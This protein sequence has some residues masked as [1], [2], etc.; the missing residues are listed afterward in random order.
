MT[1][2]RPLQEPPLERSPGQ[3]GQLVL[4]TGMS[5]AGMSVALKALEDLGYEAVDNLRLSLV[6]ALLEQADPRRRPL[7]LVID[8]R[9]R[10]FSAHAMLEEVEALKAHAE[11]E[12][13]LVFL[14]CG[15]ETLQRRFT[16]TRRRHPL[17]IDRP[18]PDGIQLERAMLLPLKQQADVTIDT[19][20]LSIHDLRRI[21]AG[22]FQIGTQ[23]A[24]QVFVTSFSFRMG[25]PR[26]ADLV[27]DVR[28]L[29]NPHYD[30]DLRPLT[31]LDPRVAARVEGDPDFAEFFRHLTDLLQ[32][33]L[34]RYNQEGKSYLTIAVGCTG[35]KHRSVFVAERL[36]AWLD[37]LGLKVG[38]SHRELERQAPR[39]G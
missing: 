27:F 31:G 24:L 33:L 34:P 28:F 1:D 19:T 10:D 15:D 35:G 12:V 2:P 7:A 6:P 20:Q 37:G 23:A 18:V 36:A 32:P 29:T 21:L 22:N 25:L 13:R 16:E 30:P 38:I 17:A 26:E 4:V 9:T 14:D 39:A 8:S 11:L 5:G 3:G